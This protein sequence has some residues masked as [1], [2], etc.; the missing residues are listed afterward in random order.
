MPLPKICPVCN[1]GYIKFSGVGTEKIESELS[2]LFPQARIRRL[3]DTPQSV[4]DDADICIATESLI[5]KGNLQ[6]DTIGVLSIDNALNRAELRASEKA[7][8]LLAELFIIARKL[9]VIQ[10]H[11]VKHHCIRAVERNDADFF[12]S[13]EL[14]TR[15]ELSFPPYSHLAHIKVRGKNA[16]RVEKTCRA[17][18]DDL[19]Q[20]ADTV[21]GITLLSCTCG[22]PAR[23]R[24]N[25]YWQI[26][27]RAGRAGA[28][29][30]FLKLH[31]RKFSHSGIITTVDI[32]PL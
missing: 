22:S 18:F 9:L 30:K 20:E 8:H 12:Y 23:L 24:G 13:H 28:L 2:R 5:R 6:F 4:S 14:K 25:F 29:S 32:D 26:L 17:L 7:F 27:G 16:E 11:L 3:D 19:K 15:Q 21:K 10:T 1:A 31:V